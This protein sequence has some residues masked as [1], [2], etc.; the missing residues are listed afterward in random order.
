MEKAPPKPK[1]KCGLGECSKKVTWLVPFTKNEGEHYCDIHMNEI[2]LAWGAHP[3]N[4]FTPLY[5]QAWPIRMP[6][7]ND[8]PKPVFRFVCRFGHF[9]FLN[10]VRKDEEEKIRFDL[11]SYFRHEC[12]ECQESALVLTKSLN[13]KAFQG[14]GIFTKL[15]KQNLD[16][17]VA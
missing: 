14:K 4:R 15:P 7:E 8:V 2:L 3:V 16:M 13:E 11:V 17:E 9:G 1:P 10:I 6:K 5:A 12:K